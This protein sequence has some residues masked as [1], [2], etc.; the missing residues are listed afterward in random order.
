M[1]KKFAVAA[2]LSAAVIA[3]KPAMATKP[4]AF[5]TKTTHNKTVTVH[6]LSD[7]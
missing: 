3:V 7:E 1:F 6:H 5:V 4:K 2:S